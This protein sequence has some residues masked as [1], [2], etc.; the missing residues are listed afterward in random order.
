MKFRYKDHIRNPPESDHN[1][2]NGSYNELIPVLSCEML[3]IE[4]SS[5]LI[6]N[7][8]CMFEDSETLNQKLK[9]TMKA[10]PVINTH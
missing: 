4:H 8:S 1:S 3:R 5:V 2:K 9:V 6:A 10:R 7:P